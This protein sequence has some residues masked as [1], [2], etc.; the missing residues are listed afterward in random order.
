MSTEIA[1]T[2]TKDEAIE[3]AIVGGDLSKLTVPERVAYYLQ[4]CKSMGLNPLT[5]P[6]DYV[7]LNGKLQFY[8]N[9]NCAEQLRQNRKVNLE[10]MS[11]ELIEGVYVVTVKMSDGGRSDMA[12][13]C[14]A[15]DNL[16]GTDRANAM[17]KCETKAK[18]RGTLS[19]CGLGMLDESEIETIAT[20][21]RVSEDWDPEA[22]AKMRQLE[23]EAKAERKREAEA[24]TKTAKENI[25]FLKSEF[26]AW[27]A[28]AVEAFH[29]KIL[30][31]GKPEKLSAYKPEELAKLVEA[32][33]KPE[34]KPKPP[35]AETREPRHLEATMPKETPA[36]PKAEAPASS[37]AP[38]T[39]PPAVVPP[40]AP[41]AEE[42]PREP[43]AQGTRDELFELMGHNRDFK[44]YAAI[45]EKHAGSVHGL[46]EITE[47]EGQAI[48]VDLRKLVEG[49]KAR[50]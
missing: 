26:S 45:K 23:S 3:A 11:A 32:L 7:V 33:P 1:R 6:F 41:K 15:L 25:E 14:V 24:K 43:M 31:H 17:M 39:P 8:A 21:R 30:G 20:A 5:K 35:T 34:D 2:G 47:S 10:S 4:T 36:E 40:E 37:P 13:G 29:V 42:K 12:T 18:R 38:E 49:Q 50:A 9:K 28:E 48:L 16:K 27:D 44:A 19:L 46:V 22:D